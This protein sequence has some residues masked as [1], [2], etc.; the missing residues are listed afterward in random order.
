MTMESAGINEEN[1]MTMNLVRAD[2]NTSDDDLSVQQIVVDV[3]LTEIGI[4]H[5]RDADILRLV[6]LHHCREQAEMIFET[7]GDLV[8]TGTMRGSDAGI[9]LRDQSHHNLIVGLPEKQREDRD[10]ER[11]LRDQLHHPE[12]LADS[13]PEAGLLERKRE[14]DVGTL[15]QCLLRHHH[16]KFANNHLAVLAEKTTMREPDVEI[17]LPDLL[18]RDQEAAETSQDHLPRN[19]IV[20]QDTKRTDRTG[21][22]EVITGPR[23]NLNE[24]SRPKTKRRNGNESLLPC[25]RT[26]PS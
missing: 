10:E 9:R 21:T 26:P 7:E 24:K 19:T 17:A 8:E 4:I 1:E 3:D 13:L 2:P 11:V 5:E 15:L 18:H 22:R 23:I 16:E 25:N 6:P 14:P 20:A 12:K